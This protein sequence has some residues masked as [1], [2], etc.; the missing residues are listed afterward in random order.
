MKLLIFLGNM[1]LVILVL[2]V[3]VVVVF[4][5]ICAFV[6]IVERTLECPAE[7]EERLKAKA[8]KNKKGGES[9]A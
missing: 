1:L 7:K 3:I 5:L 2:F 9:D 4:F 6:W 8:K